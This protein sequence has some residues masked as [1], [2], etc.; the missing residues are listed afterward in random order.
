M[1]LWVRDD[2]D[3]SFRRKYHVFCI[4]DLLTMRQEMCAGYTL[5]WHLE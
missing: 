3:Q 4:A 5:H 2:G 1:G